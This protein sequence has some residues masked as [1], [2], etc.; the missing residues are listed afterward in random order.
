VKVYIAGPMTGKEHHNFPAF[1]EAEEQLVKMGHEP[2][3]PAWNNGETLEEAIA[4][5]DEDGRSL[6][7]YMRKDMVYLS[8]SD[9]IVVL[10]GW[11]ESRGACFE[12]DVAN[13]LNIPVMIIKDNKLVP[14]IQI[15]GLAGY[16]RSGKD[17]V[18]ETLV[19]QGWE[20]AS[21]ASPIKEAVYTL[22]PKV[23]YDME[24]L[25]Y[26]H[27]VDTYGIDDAKVKYPEVRRLLQVF[28]TE[29]GREMF[30]QNFWVEQAIASVPDGGKVVF[31]DVRYPNEA[32]SIRYL[33]GQIWWV[34]RDG[35]EALNDHPSENSLD[36]FMFDNTINNNGTI[37]ELKQQVLDGLNIH[38]VLTEA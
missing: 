36:G 32:N 25:D 4:N 26:Q 38:L 22:N 16:A 9:L 30:G 3:N 23:A 37:D 11:R 29:V 18:A 5:V 13:A 2:L 8:Q 6:L 20:K 28:G 7:E 12:V 10:D 15:M 21:F 24:D 27:V 35:V 14:R 34:Q 17:T 19:E 1:F 31:S 33:G